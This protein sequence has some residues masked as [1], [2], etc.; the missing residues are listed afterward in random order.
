[1]S[2]TNESI[3]KNEV[4]I[5]VAKKMAV[6]ART[7]P[8]A[9]G[10]DNL[11]IIII[12][13]ETI[14]QLSDKMLEIGT[15]HDIHFFLRDAKNILNANAILVIGSRIK[16][17]GLKYC[18]MCGFESCEEKNQ[19]PNTPCV[20]NTHDLGLAIGSA[21]SI[22]ME[23]RIDNRVMYSIGKAV[24]DLQLLG[25]DIKVALGIP[26]SALAKNPFFD[27]M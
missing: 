21:V 3:I 16:A 22:A 10:T 6:A 23:N 12:E 8:K 26:L 18:G 2:I 13:G 15:L 25:S 1:M 7:A 27:R 9:R 17:Q 20:F 4:I 14:K 24:L 19:Y 11:E 5:E